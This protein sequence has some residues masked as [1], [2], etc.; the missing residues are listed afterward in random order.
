MV[1]AESTQR[2]NKP[3][4]LSFSP[5]LNLQIARTGSIV[6]FARVANILYNPEITAAIPTSHLLYHC[7]AAFPATTILL[8]KSPTSHHEEKAIIFVLRSTR[9]EVSNRSSKQIAHRPIPLFTS[10]FLPHLSPP[11]SSLHPFIS[12][13]LQHSR[14]VQHPEHESR[15]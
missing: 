13:P 2:S 4:S 7:L 5:S 9:Q 6:R 11:L 1:V 3:N 10:L 12:T 8:P 14:H 15:H